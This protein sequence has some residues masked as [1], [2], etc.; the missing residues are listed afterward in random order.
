M[1]RWRQQGVG[2]S[3]ECYRLKL[4]DTHQLSV[5]ADDNLLGE[6]VLTG[7]IETDRQKN[8]ICR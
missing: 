6:T 2:A 8:F 5:Y 4:N 1:N 3:A 7:P